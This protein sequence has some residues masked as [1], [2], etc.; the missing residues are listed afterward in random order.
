MPVLSRVR[1]F[2]YGLKIK[3]FG[4][5]KRNKE[6]KP[7][8]KKAGQSLF[9][10]FFMLFPVVQFLVFYVG[11]NINSIALAFTKYEK[12]VPKFAGFENFE[13]VLKAIFVTGE[14]RLALKNSAIQFITGLLIGMPL[15]VMVAYVVFKK[16]PLSSFYK[17]MLFMPNILSS[18]V[19][20]ICLRVL[21]DDGIPSIIHDFIIT[22]MDGTSKSFYAILIFGLWMN[23]AGGLVIYLSAMCGI[24]Q[25]IIEYGELENMSSLQE[26]W[27]IV[28][29]SIFPTIVTYI[30]VAIGGFF[31]NYGHFYSYYGGS[32]TGQK[33]YDTLGY[34]F[35]V[36]VSNSVDQNKDYVFAAAGGIIFTLVVA[37]IT[38]VT[39][40]LLEK[41]GPSED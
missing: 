33:P 10:F 29:P 20:V 16:A 3:I 6:P 8:N 41:Y 38:L 4:G 37:P 34:N 7:R 39:K 30:V 25:D 18:L 15:Q 28:L 1:W 19:F 14:L 2:F 21:L 31:T 24:S 22:P 40:H 35:F 27:Y 11:V 13:N 17:I 23:F 36:K 5:E 32:G 9:L 12:N 26:F